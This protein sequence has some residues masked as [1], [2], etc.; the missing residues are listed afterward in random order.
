MT[1]DCV[2]CHPG[3][4][5]LENSRHRTLTW[6]QNSSEGKRDS[7]IELARADRYA[8]DAIAKAL[9]DDNCGQTEVCGG[10]LEVL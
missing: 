6:P 10:E 2:W 8:L 5:D 4:F 7:N 3:H 1:S 9:R